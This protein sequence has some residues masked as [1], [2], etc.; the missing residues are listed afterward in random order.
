MADV[1]QVS[2]YG[3]GGVGKTTITTNLAVCLAEAGE[4]PM[5]VGCSP[6]SDS[7]TL[8][9]GGTPAKPVVL[10]NILA[11]GSNKASVEECVCHGFGGIACLEAGGP[12]PAS[13]CAG[14]GIYHTLQLL[15]K[16]R[17]LEEYQTTYAIYDAIADVVCGGFSLP[18]RI[19][20]STTVYIVTTA[21]MMSLYAANNICNAALAVNQG[22]LEAL[23]V[24]GL[25]L[26]GRQIPGEIKIVEDFAALLGLPVVAYIPHSDLVQEAEASQ[27]TVMAR[28]PES[29]LAQEFRRLAVQLRHPNGIV[30]EPISPL[31]SLDVITSIIYKYQ[32]DGMEKVLQ[33]AVPNPVQTS[34]RERSKTPP[35]RRIAIYGKAGIGKSTTSSNLSAAL[36]EQGRRVLQVGCDPKRDS[37]AQLLHCLPPT[38]LDQL[39]RQQEHDSFDDLP[40]DS[41]FFQGFNQVIC[42]ESGGPPP[43]VGCAGQGVLLAL[44]FIEQQQVMDKYQIDFSV[45]DVLGDVVC[46]G[47]AQPMRAGYCREIYV[48]IN[49]DPLSLVVTNN[50]LQA[51]E[52]LSREGVDV[53]LGGLIN[54]Q[55]NGAAAEQLVQSFAERVG[56][57]IIGHIPRSPL[58]LAAEARRQTVMEA[59][60]ESDIAGLYRSLAQ[61]IIRNH[62]IY[63][64]RALNNTESIY[65]LAAENLPTI[66]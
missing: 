1:T 50:I 66:G 57:P 59:F 64:P 34:E 19:D 54:N 13:G 9:M 56:I 4:R 8:L 48:V 39:N 61:A 24:G 53:G 17:I 51:V 6:K 26:S 3:K 35:R 30:P 20:F 25:I 52:K 29:S 5:L 65:D 21:E 41:I 32:N 63:T 15:K 46:G 16:Y 12:S 33:Q 27:S 7:T 14:R 55:H 60:P 2:I 42:A 58:V 28:F 31:E 22:R 38:I 36:A 62:K 10:D 18:M 40:L 37:V 11:R 44:Q 47:F 43:G 45:F 49:G 23:Q